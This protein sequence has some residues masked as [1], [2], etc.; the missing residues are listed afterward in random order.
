MSWM[1]AWGAWV[2]AAVVFAVLE[3]LLP[4]SVFLGFAIGA[5]VV[6]VLLVLGGAAFVGGS[7]PWMMVI[8]AAVSLIA[9]LVLRRVFALRKGQ[10]KV[11]TTDIND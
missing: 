2:V 7:V 6:A 5:V 8:F 3:I 9:W 10:V 11:W 4:A 1:F